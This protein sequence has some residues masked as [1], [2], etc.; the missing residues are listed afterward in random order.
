MQRRSQNTSI[1]QGLHYNVDLL[2]VKHSIEAN[3]RQRCGA[4]CATY[5]FQIARTFST[6][7]QQ[8]FMD[9]QVHKIKAG[10]AS[11]LEHIDGLWKNTS[12]L[13]ENPRLPP[14]YGILTSSTSECVNSMFLEARSLPGSNRKDH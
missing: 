5:V 9:K 14:R 11:Y 8:S 6:R 1:S 12:W 13:E 3:V 10:A 7:Q 4:E 2:C